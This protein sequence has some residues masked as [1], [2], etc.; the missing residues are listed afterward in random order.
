MWFNRRNKYC[1]PIFL[2]R[3]TKSHTGEYLAEKVAESLKEYGLDLSI[4]S[5]TMDNAS[6]NDGLLRELPHL[7]PSAATVGTHYQ[8]R[9]FG[10]II[11]LCVKAFLSL[12]DSS[13]KAL[14]A[15][16]DAQPD[17]G[18][19]TDDEEDSDDEDIAEDQEVDEDQEAERDAGDWEEIEK[20]SSELL[21]VSMLGVE[22]KIAGRRT[23]KKVRT[24]ACCVCPF[25]LDFSSA[26]LAR[27]F[28]T[29]MCFRRSLPRLAGTSK[30]N[31]R[32]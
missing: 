23:M 5:I 16:G 32:R 17:E 7:L 31:Q 15:D 26:N 8:I 11:N 30:F 21:E 14:K 28:A 18:R 27:S 10:H 20:L 25:S 24:F 19:D 9:C 22:D 1:L 6:N 2:F 4:L 3:L 13:K 29:P 12:F